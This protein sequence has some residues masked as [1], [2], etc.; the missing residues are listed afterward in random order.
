MDKRVE[1]GYTDNMSDRPNNFIRFC[2]KLCNTF[3]VSIDFIE[4]IS[5]NN[6]NYKV[7][8]LGESGL[9]E[10]NY[11]Y[12]DSILEYNINGFSDEDTASI[13]K[14]ILMAFTKVN[15]KVGD[16]IFD[17]YGNIYEV[18]EDTNIPLSENGLRHGY[19]I[20]VKDSLNNIIEKDDRFMSSI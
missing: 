17:L 5:V 10:V 6:R 1:I 20:K 7:R 12:G 11:N 15:Y 2:S 14:Y 16:V 9:I 13:D 18:I 3:K 8:F 4:D 19:K